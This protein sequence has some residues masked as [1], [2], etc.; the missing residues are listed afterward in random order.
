MFSLMKLLV[1]TPFG[2]TVCVHVS[3]LT[4]AERWQAGRQAGD[5]ELPLK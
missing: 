4:E 5:G 3:G 2:R 1:S